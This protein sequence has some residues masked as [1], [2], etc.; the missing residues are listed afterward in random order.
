MGL[1]LGINVGHDAGISLVD[2]D[3]VL[4]AENEERYSRVKNHNGYPFLSLKNLFEQISPKAISRVGIEGKK[5]LPM[6][7]T[8]E[9]QKEFDSSLSAYSDSLSIYKLFLSNRFGIDLAQNSLHLYQLRR[10]ATILKL[11]RTIGIEASIHFFDHHECHHA[12][13]TFV[14][15]AQTETETGVSVSFDASGEAWCSKVFLYQGR[16]LTEIKSLR[17]PS[18]YSPAN[19]YLN[20]TKVLGFRPLRHEGKVMGLAAR[21]NP[22]ETRQLLSEAFRFNEYQGKWENRLG[23]RE[24]MQNWLRKELRDYSREDVSAGTQALVEEAVCAYIERKIVSFNPS[25]NFYFSGGLF[26]NVRLNQ[27]I[28]ESPWCDRA[29]VAPNM[30]D[31]GL[32][33]GAAL[34]A[35]NIDID[36]SKRFLNPSNLFL[37]HYIGRSESESVARH[38]KSNFQIIADEEYVIAKALANNK[39]IAIARE[40][41]EFGPRALGN[42]S[43]IYRATDSSVNNWLNRQLGRSE[44]MP[45]A[46]VLTFESA[47]EILELNSGVDYSNMTVTCRIKE[48]FLSKYPAIAH[49]DGTARPQIVYEGS[50]LHKILNIYK[51]LTGLEVLVNTSFNMHE[52]PI[53]RS[54][55]DAIKAFEASGVDL[56]FLPGI[57]VANRSIGENLPSN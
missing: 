19:L 15:F 11:L 32:N 21:G 1:F 5:I 16:N 47:K 54:A 20:V 26:A 53:V 41:M 25:K 56:L 30:G 17:L 14:Q 38:N 28:A 51:S 55:F 6:R 10:R 34:L 49:V 23:Y 37:G 24:R 9:G 18:Y 50:F 44:F 4:L 27:K 40:G 57:V 29:Y 33:L 36:S 7:N 35:R 48:G 52:E 2:S 22:I 31:G 46:P 8:P 13:A 12:S 42:R 43:I 45:F 39:V 3:R